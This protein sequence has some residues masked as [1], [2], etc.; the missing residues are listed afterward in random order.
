MS[1]IERS[2]VLARH[3][4]RTGFLKGKILSDLQIPVPRNIKLHKFVR[5]HLP[6][7]D[8]D[9]KRFCQ[10][11]HKVGFED[12]KQLPASVYSFISSGYRN[13]P[14]IGRLL[15]EIVEFTLDRIYLSIDAPGHWDRTKFG[16]LEG[17]GVFDAIHGPVGSHYGTPSKAAVTKR[18]RHCQ[19]LVIA[20]LFQTAHEL[21]LFVK[22]NKDRCPSMEYL[23]QECQGLFLM[24]SGSTYV[25]SRRAPE[26]WIE[27]YRNE[28]IPD[29]FVEQLDDEAFKLLFYSKEEGYKLKP[30]SRKLARQQ[31][32]E[33]LVYNPPNDQDLEY[34]YKK[35]IEDPVTLEHE[36]LMRVKIKADII[37]E[38]RMPRKAYQ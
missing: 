12:D 2:D 27:E 31:V 34:T 16:G 24:E 35:Y 26:K 3:K 28:V 18:Y 29:E 8:P 25:T 6:D 9:F 17:Q 13:N 23:K 33:K 1:R 11:K 14:K 15:F 22:K 19:Y 36:Y 21:E 20:T 32:R 37:V 5:F 38:L 10:L 30:E 7:H 4:E